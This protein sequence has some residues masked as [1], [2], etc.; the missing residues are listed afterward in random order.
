[1]DA[2]AEVHPHFEKKSN[3]RSWNTL[4]RSEDTT[5]GTRKLRRYINA[6]LWLLGQSFLTKE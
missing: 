2:E 1:M 3:P 5:C 6:T 4:K